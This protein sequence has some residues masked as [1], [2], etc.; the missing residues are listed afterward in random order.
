MARHIE[1]PKVVSEWSIKM[2]REQQV[3]LLYAVSAGK[4]IK[5][6]LLDDDSVRLTAGIPTDLMPDDTGV[7]PVAD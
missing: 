4:T 5:V 6:Q 1:A 3:Y 7:L 2:T